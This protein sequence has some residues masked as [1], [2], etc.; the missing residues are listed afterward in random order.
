VRAAAEHEA[1]TPASLSAAQP[2]AKIARIA[3]KRRNLIFN[4]QFWQLPIV[5]IYRAF[6]VLA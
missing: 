3:K 2:I 5:A 6:R 4:F 1:R